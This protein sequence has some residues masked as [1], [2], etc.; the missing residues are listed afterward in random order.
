MDMARA[1]YAS[2]RPV[3]LMML[4]GADHAVS[5]RRDEYDQATRNWFDRYVRDLERFPD[6]VPHGK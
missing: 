2:K 1:L 3:R 5:Q 6:S 4:E